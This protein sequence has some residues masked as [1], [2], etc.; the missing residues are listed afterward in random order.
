MFPRG[1]PCEDDDERQTQF[2]TIGDRYDEEH[3]KK[4]KDPSGNCTTRTERVSGQALCVCC[5]QRAAVR[6]LANSPN[7]AFHT[8]SRA[9]SFE[10]NVVRRGPV[11][12][13]VRWPKVVYRIVMFSWLLTL[14]GCTPHPDG[15]SI[16]RSIRPLTADEESLLATI[17]AHE[18]TELRARYSL[19]DS[20]DDLALLQRVMDD[21]TFSRTKDMQPLGVVW[22]DLV[23]R[24]VGTKWITA[25]WE[26]TRMLAINVPHSTILLF[27]IGMLEER[28]D[29]GET[30][31]FPL[32][33]TNT[34]DAV[35]R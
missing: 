14:L 16:E 17:R 6:T 5:R 3:L 23:C 8:Q 22:G 24:K 31:D 33:L 25:E 28:R 1:R 20:A 13:A 15:L 34:V 18:I 11:N 7:K 29:R 19:K 12:A 9:R 26:G 32:F 2:D 4:W 35:K 27:P 10:F 30:V 21:G